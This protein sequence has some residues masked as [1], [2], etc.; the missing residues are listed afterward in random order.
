MANERLFGG[1]KFI[2]GDE[3]SR[4]SGK[5]SN[6]QMDHIRTLTWQGILKHRGSVKE[7]MRIE[8][9]RPDLTGVLPTGPVPPSRPSRFYVE[10]L[11]REHTA[12]LLHI[13]FVS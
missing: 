7:L 5:R 4:S 1:Q 10:S 11:L 2:R 3:E 13:N 12:T 9:P 6:G 8:S